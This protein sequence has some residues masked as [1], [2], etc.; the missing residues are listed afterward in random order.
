MTTIVYDV[1]N[2]S[3][4]KEAGKTNSVQPGLYPEAYAN[5]SLRDGPPAHQVDVFGWSLRQMDKLEIPQDDLNL[6]LG[7]NAVRLFKLEDKVPHTRLF[8]Q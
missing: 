4:L 7:G 6:I 8:K 1:I 2:I 5:Q 3:Y